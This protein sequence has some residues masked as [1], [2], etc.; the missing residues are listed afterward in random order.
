MIED[1]S[2]DY[3]PEMNNRFKVSDFK[4]LDTYVNENL[5][6]AEEK[7]KLKRT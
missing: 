2:E 5:K 4:D 3:K 6:K 7:A 1:G